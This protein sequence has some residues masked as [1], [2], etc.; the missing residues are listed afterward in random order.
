M[1]SAFLRLDKIVLKCA[2]TYYGFIRHHME[3]LIMVI[4]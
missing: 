1:F 3:T 4:C 2:I